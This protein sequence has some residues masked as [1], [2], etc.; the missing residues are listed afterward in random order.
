[1]KQVFFLDLKS[2]ISMR[3]PIDFISL[4]RYQCEK[5]PQYIPE[6]FG[7][8]EPLNNDFDEKNIEIII[9]P[10]RGGRA[11]NVW[12]K[13]KKSD[14]A[15][16]AWMPRWES[17]VDYLGDTHASISMSV[18][19]EKHCGEILEF[20]K[21]AS[22]LAKC[23][24]AYFD[25]LTPD[26]ASYAKESKFSQHGVL[27]LTT[28]Q[29]RHWLPDVAWANVYGEAYTRLF[30]MDALMSAPAYKVEALSEDSVFIQLTESPSDLYARHDSVAEARG[31]VRRHLGG[32]RFFYDP[33]LAYDQRENPGLAGKVFEVPEFN[34]IED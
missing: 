29:M 5:L 10:D 4:V 6:K 14:K 33:K 28:H 25:S 17:A 24:I 34:L 8:F 27:G 13:R 21:I 20:M 12:W 1:M 26:Y 16:G 7:W 23:D 2:R 31:E 18:F 19:S 30:G 32:S 3:N 11:D 9:P 15:D 22:L